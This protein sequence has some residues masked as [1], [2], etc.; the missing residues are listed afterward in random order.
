VARILVVDDERSAR[1]Y[2]RLLLE[3]EGHET[4]LAGDGV[5]AL[6][7][8]EREVYALVITDLHMPE[9]DG[10]ELLAHVKQRWPGLPVIV[11]T[12]ASDVSEIVDVVQRGATNYI[13]K[14]AAPATVTDAVELALAAG[15][16]RPSEEH[17]AS[18]IIGSSKAIVEVRHRVAMAARSDVP[19]LITGETGTGKEL[20]AQAIHRACGPADRPFVAHNCAVS[21]RDLFESQFFGHR[22]GAFTG[23]DQ[24]HKGLLREADGGVLFLDELET[25][26]PLFQA[27]LLRVLDDGDVR[28]VGSEKTYHVSVR[29][30]AATN[31][32]ARTMLNEGI[33]REDLYYRLRGFEILL[34]PLSQRPGD[35]PALV[36]H[37]LDEGAEVSAEALV[38]LQAA[39]WPGNIRELR[40]VVR[41]ASAVAGEVPIQ[42][43]HLPPEF[44]E[45]H[46]GPPGQNGAEADGPLTLKQIEKRA[47]LHALESCG[48][49][50]SRTARMLDIDRSTLRRKLQEFEI[51]LKS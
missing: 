11:I 7:E 13:V 5:E 18:H 2:L 19:V 24:D 48:G 32:D 47:I 40:N 42:L 25:L 41:S 9:M 15:T 35:I 46:D 6:V 16:R 31:R 30:I 23:A 49:N 10:L 17:F 27:K 1:E 39:H 26:E 4:G 50:R 43:G 3:Q 14:P 36:D 33:L 37:F 38:A 12:A 34:P 28:P 29:F 44:G 51:N 45:S 21:P 22:K 8:L 20:V